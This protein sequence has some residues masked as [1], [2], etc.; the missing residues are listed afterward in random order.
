MAAAHQNAAAPTNKKPA[1]TTTRLPSLRQRLAQA[2]AMAWT[3][4]N[5]FSPAIPNTLLRLLALWCVSTYIVLA[6]VGTVMVRTVCAWWGGE[7]GGRSKSRRGQ[8]L[9]HVLTQFTSSC[10]PNFG[11]IYTPAPR[12]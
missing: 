5:V 8:D 11:S 10:K 12:P 4:L 2:S 9:R 1:T 6:F 3:V 7:S